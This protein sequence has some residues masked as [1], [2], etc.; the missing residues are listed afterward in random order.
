MKSSK[1]CNPTRFI[2][3]KNCLIIHFGLFGKF[4]FPTLGTVSGYVSLFS[5]GKFYS[6]KFLILFRSD[7]QPDTLITGTY[8]KEFIRNTYDTW[9]ENSFRVSRKFAHSHI[10]IR[11]WLLLCICNI[12]V[13]LIGASS[14]FE[15]CDQKTVRMRP[16][17]TRRHSQIIQRLPSSLLS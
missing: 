3:H 5:R 1:D 15:V 9:S 11:I 2:F 7:S 10:N 16:N 13:L 4:G 17:H 8:V 14:K 6:E 12:R